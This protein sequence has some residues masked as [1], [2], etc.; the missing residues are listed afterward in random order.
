MSYRSLVLGGALLQAG[1]AHAVGLGNIQVESFLGAPLQ[2]SA[3]LVSTKE[4]GVREIKAKVASIEVYDR[5]GA[6]FE[7]QHNHLEFSISTDANGDMG[8]KIRSTSSITEPFLDIVV[9]LSWPEGTTYRRYNLLLDPPQYAAKLNRLQPQLTPVETATS[10]I[11]HDSKARSVDKNNTV[12]T[13]IQL[14]E[15]YEVQKGDSLWKLAKHS[16]RAAGLSQHQM[17]DVLFQ[18]NSDAFIRGDK[19]KL[20]L[21]AVI[22]VPNQTQIA[23]LETLS[24]AT[25][26]NQVAK[27]DMAVSP[28]LVESPSDSSAAA[29]PPLPSLPVMGKTLLQQDLSK[30]TVADIDALKKELAQLLKE[31]E[32]LVQHQQELRQLLSQ[33]KSDNSQQRLQQPEP[34]QP[35]AKLAVDDWAEPLNEADQSQSAADKLAELVK[36]ASARNQNEGPAATAAMDLIANRD[37]KTNNGLLAS[38]GLWY[39]LGM[40]PLGMLL[41]L[42]G[43]RVHR[44][45]AL[46]RDEQ[47]TG[48]DLYD[49]VFG[50]KR[51]RAKTDSPEQIKKAMQQIRKKAD[52]FE[53]QTGNN[54][55]HEMAR[56]SDDV[57]KMI[58]VYLVYSQYQKALNVILTEISKQPT[59]K[60]LRLYLMQVY[61]F[62]EDWKAFDEQLVV[63]EKMGDPALVASA[64]SIRN[65]ASRA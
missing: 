31:R 64:V 19:S 30:A 51:D 26:G 47:S 54:N 13:H 24:N 3:D 29:I 42:L 56:E 21:G 57:S 55:P 49:L 61:A 38:K 25:Y 59:R 18:N 63:L 40:L 8:L 4:Y 1:M 5:F 52:Q 10:L 65:E 23:N 6:R 44:V 33:Q 58:E 2:A 60:D 11:V 53:D 9:E 41:A 16:R 46:K 48:E 34:A 14:G 15:S 37:L 43:M 12:E 62:M 39:A 22:Q 45:Q 27:V 36:E 28:E 35:V 17:M 32:Q 7:P 20:K 50:A